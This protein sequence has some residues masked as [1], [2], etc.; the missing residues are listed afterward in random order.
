MVSSCNKVVLNDWYKAA[1]QGNANLFVENC[2]AASRYTKSNAVSNYFACVNV[3]Y[4][5]QQTA[6]VKVTL[7][8]KSYLFRFKCPSRLLLHWAPKNSISFFHLLLIKSY[9][10]DLNVW[11][12]SWL[13]SLFKAS[14]ALKNVTFI[15][16]LLVIDFYF[17]QSTFNSRASL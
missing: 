13:D 4:C 16:N 15:I 11:V 6:C 5:F 14:Q 1:Q 9:Y 2:Y 7:L 17:F 3:E 8:F 12:Y 10:L